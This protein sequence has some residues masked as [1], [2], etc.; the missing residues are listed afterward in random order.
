MG[1]GVMGIAG[2][3]GNQIILVRDALA[4]EGRD[5]S[6]Y[7]TRAGSSGCLFGLPQI[8]DEQAKLLVG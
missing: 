3:E 8:R 6:R 5:I 7:R 4:S 2:I 1:K